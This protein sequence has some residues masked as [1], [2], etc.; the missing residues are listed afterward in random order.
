MV[1]DLIL[2]M[3]R[4]VIYFV[5]ICLCAIVLSCASLLS[6]SIVIKTEILL[7]ILVNNAYFSA[8]PIANLY[9]YFF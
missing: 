1:R 4:Y 9:I 5:H 6:L 3:M 7:S 8:K 2:K